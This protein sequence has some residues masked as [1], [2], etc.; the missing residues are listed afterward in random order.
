MK[1]I[2]VPLLNLTLKEKC[3]IIRVPLLN[4]T[5]MVL[6]ENCGGF[7][8]ER[9]KYIKVSEIA[10][11][12]ANEFVEDLGGILNSIGIE[13][14]LSENGTMIARY[15]LPNV[16]KLLWRGAGAHRKVA[17]KTME[18]AEV[19]LLM[20]SGETAERLAEDLGI[21]R[22]TFFRRLKSAEENGYKY[23]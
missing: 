8:M 2:R 9:T 4:L 10:I 21:S 7:E 22:R 11:Q 5:L 16:R 19:K 1:K 13:L 15:D 12:D 17:K 23:I 14:H 20:N 6:I 3:G 18:V